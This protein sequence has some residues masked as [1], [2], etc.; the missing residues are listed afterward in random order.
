MD[1]DEWDEVDANDL[2]FDETQ[3]KPFLQFKNNAR[4]W[5]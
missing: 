2:S 1:I 5:L 3:E 4:K